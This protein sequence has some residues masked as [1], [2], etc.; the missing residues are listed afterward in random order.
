MI[1]HHTFLLQNF[2]I[3]VSQYLL[4][5]TLPKGKKIIDNKIQNAKKTEVYED[6]GNI[7]S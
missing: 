2:I 4:Y 7:G 5:K 6:R 1:I 3:N